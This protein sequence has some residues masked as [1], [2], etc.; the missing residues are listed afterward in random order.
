MEDGKPDKCADAYGKSARVKRE[1]DPK[2]ASELVNKALDLLHDNE[3][4][5]MMP[6]LGRLNVA[7]TTKAGDYVAA[8]A[9]VKLNIRHLEALQQPHNITK[10]AIE[11]VVLH[12]AR[13]DAVLAKREFSSLSSKYVH[14]DP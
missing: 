2:G 5:H 6:E 13:D 12:L 1:S 10:A 8:A 4:L 11:L 3:L 14:P 7:I 9:A